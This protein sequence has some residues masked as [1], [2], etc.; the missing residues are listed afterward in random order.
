MSDDETRRFLNT[1]GGLLLLI[2]SAVI[3]LPLLCC[4]GTLAIGMMSDATS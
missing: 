3:A 2:L 1:S 4:V